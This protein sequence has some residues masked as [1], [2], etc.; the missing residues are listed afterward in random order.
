M[1]TPHSPSVGSERSG[2]SYYLN[3][4]EAKIIIPNLSSLHDKEDASE[5]CATELSENFMERQE[6]MN[7]SCDFGKATSDVREI[8][9]EPVAPV[10]PVKERMMMFEKGIEKDNDDL[11]LHEPAF[12][13]EE[14]SM[15]VKEQ[16]DKFERLHDEDLNESLGQFI[17]N[18]LIENVHV[19]ETVHD[20]EK[21]E[22]YHEENLHDSAMGQF[23]ENELVENVHVMETVHDLEKSEFNHEEVSDDPAL[24]QFHE[25]ELTEN[26]HVME[27]VHDL[28]KSVLE[29]ESAAVDHEVEVV[30]TKIHVQETVHYLEHEFDRSMP[31]CDEYVDMV[32]H[33]QD[34]GDAPAVGIIGDESAGMS[35]QEGVEVY[36]HVNLSRAEEATTK[37][38]TVTVGDTVV[39]RDLDLVKENESSNAQSTQIVVVDV[40]PCTENK[41]K[42][43]EATY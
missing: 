36:C 37:T 17:E 19:M 8:P 43:R 5:G 23:H 34:A 38:V 26:V 14:A 20:L 31:V 42:L 7:Y 21:S 3:E 29:S 18:E 25:N 27:T 30:P 16:I 40:N 2:A 1:V 9:V 6:T 22:H 28:E 35:E 10:T 39:D 13:E 15:H 12:P 24:G 41:P 32:S 33:R 11:L 4:T